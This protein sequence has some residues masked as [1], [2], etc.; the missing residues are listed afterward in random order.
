MQ[1]I[2]ALKD[3][4]YDVVGSILNVHK[5][6]D[7]GLNEY[8][9][10]EALGLELMSNGIEFKKEMSFHPKFKGIELESTYRVDFLCKGDIVVECKSIIEVG[11]NNRAQLFN[12]MRLLGAPCGILVNF[13]PYYAA[14]E[15]YFYDIET[16]DILTIEGKRF[17]MK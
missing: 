4:I 3:H 11:N 15:R 5:E 12:Y 7:P 16:M 14:V 6:L 17:S 10:Q 8:C 2:G 1:N 13:Y 9:Y